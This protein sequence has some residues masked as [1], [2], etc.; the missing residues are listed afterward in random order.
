MKLEATLLFHLRHIRLR[1]R[2]QQREVPKLQRSKA[3]WA[4]SRWMLLSMVLKLS[5]TKKA[6]PTCLTRNCNPKL[7][8]KLPTQEN[9]ANNNKHKK[10]KTKTHKSLNKK[11]KKLI[12]MHMIE[13]NNCWL[14]R[15]MKEKESNLGHR[16]LANKSRG[17]KWQQLEPS[18][19]HRC[20]LNSRFRK[21]GLS[22]P[23][24]QPN[25]LHKVLIWLGLEVL[26]EKMADHISHNRLLTPTRAL[27]IVD[28]QTKREE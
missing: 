4:K 8:M 10:L 23:S 11:R 16:W 24:L 28:R 3:K 7:W 17:P 19:H 2:G 26:I 14:L 15:L 21:E 6:S 20:C 25:Y 27:L 18:Q 5:M 9:L 13:L 12:N 1:V 22:K